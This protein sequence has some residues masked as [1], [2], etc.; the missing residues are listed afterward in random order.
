MMFDNEKPKEAVEDYFDEFFELD[1]DE[2][3]PVRNGYSVINPPILWRYFLKVPENKLE[4]LSEREYGLLL[5]KLSPGA[6]FFDRCVQPVA[7]I[8]FQSCMKATI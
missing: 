4:F 2:P 7:C 8:C 5:R 1:R 6:V 3:I